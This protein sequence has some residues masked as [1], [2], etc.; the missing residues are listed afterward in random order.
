MKRTKQL[1]NAALD[2]LRER[3]EKQDSLRRTYRTKPLELLSKFGHRYRGAMRELFLDIYEGR[4]DRAVGLACRGGGKSHE[5]ADL[6]FVLWALDDW[7]VAIVSGSREQ[8]LRVIEYVQ[9][10]T[11]DETVQDIVADETK[12]LVKGKRG[13]WIKAATASTKA[14]RGLHAKGRKMLLILDEEAEMAPE[15]VRSALLV[16]NDAKRAVVLR[17]STMHKLEGT[18]ADL[19]ANH[20]KVGYRLY[21]WD[22][23]EAATNCTTRSCKDCLK[24]FADGNEPEELAKL[25]KEFH[26]RYCQER[27]KSGAR[28]KGRGTR[29]K[30]ETRMTKQAEGT[31]EPGWIKVEE[32]RQSFMDMPRSW[33]ET[34]VM[35]LK[36]SGEGKVL[37]YEKVRSALLEL[38]LVPFTRGAPIWGCVDW[39]F[40]GQLAAEVLQQVGDDTILLE[41]TEWSEVDVDILMAWFRGIEDQFGQPLTAIYPDSSHPFENN[42]LREAGF[43]VDE[44]V[45]GSYKETGAGF[46]RWAFDR[47]KFR[48]AQRFP[49][50]VE[51]L[52]GWSRGAD[53]KIKK[54]ADHHCDAL[55]AGTKRLA[56]EAGGTARVLGGFNRRGGQAFFALRRRR[57][58]A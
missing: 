36:P 38:P 49:K 47:G 43:E 1:E 29:G 25:T 13:N 51:Q 12:M 23:F 45:F 31:R 56:G 18:F 33:F 22:A 3:L 44:V 26:D 24:A 28:G 4:V 55:L 52:T 48:T 58:A 40:R 16:C 41:S 2:A 8:A 5:A 19:V 21:K 42:R 35:A 11:G 50:V 27:V 9:D 54:V 53:G 34:E 32:I 15:I 10:I 14:V 30:P 37:D 46:L 39:G 17:L 20:A 57:G 6:G 7:N